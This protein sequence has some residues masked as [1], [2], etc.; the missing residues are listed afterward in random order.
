[1]YMHTR[2]HVLHLV[3]GHVFTIGENFLVL[4]D[5]TIVQCV[6]D[7]YDKSSMNYIVNKFISSCTCHEMVH[8]TSMVYGQR[9]FFYSINRSFKDC[10]MKTKNIFCMRWSF[11]HVL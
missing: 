3:S 5:I 8:I 1:M 2:N 4:A 9:M 7:L 6:C 11:W 10:C